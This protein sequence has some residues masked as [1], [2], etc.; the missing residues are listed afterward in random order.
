MDSFSSSS[1]A[2]P[3]SE[4]VMEKV[5]AHLAQAYAQELL[6]TVGNKCFAACVTKPG[7]SLSRSEGN[8]VSHCVD[9]YIEATGIISRAL[10]SSKP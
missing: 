5:R 2:G 10:F 8:C 4:E 9:R 7:T 1:S 6:E 3:S